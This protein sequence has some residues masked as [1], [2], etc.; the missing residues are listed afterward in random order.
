M[1]IAM[2]YHLLQQKLPNYT[3]NSNLAT[4]SLTPA[5]VS[6]IRIT[7]VL[8][9]KMNLAGHMQAVKWPTVNYGLWNILTTMK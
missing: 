9:L 2:Y 3:Q 4:R 8:E 6:E 1:F 5:S 7:K